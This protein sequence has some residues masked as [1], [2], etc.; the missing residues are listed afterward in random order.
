MARNGARS[1]WSDARRG[2]AIIAA[3]AVLALGVFF[4]DTAVRA[5]AEGERITV[6]ASSAPGLRPGSP[7]WVAGRAVGRVLSIELAEPGSETAPILI[8][9][10]LDREAEPILR[11]DAHADVGTIDLLA[12]VYVLVDPGTS[13][14]PWNFADT[15]RPSGPPIDREALLALADTLLTAS[16]RLT[17]PTESLRDAITDGA[18]T[19]SRL[20]RDP[21]LLRDLRAQLTT[22]ETLLRDELPRSSLGRLAA[23]TTL[24]ETAGRVRERLVELRESPR[25]DAALGQLRA[26]GRALDALGTRLGRLL[27]GLEAGQGTAGRALV[28]RELADRLVALRGAVRKLSDDLA[29]NPQRWLRIQI[30]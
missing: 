27:A 5:T 14:D 1:G 13:V 6:E 24:G 21:T 23:D 2:L 11:A 30:F 17:G 18:G 15:L 29:R 25:R 16:R 26:A 28:D 3:L 12:P 7:V 19:I 22:I 9:A 20:R 8:R 10:V 4:L